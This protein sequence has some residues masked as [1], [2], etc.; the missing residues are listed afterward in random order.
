MEEHV[1]LIFYPT[2]YLYANIRNSEAQVFAVSKMADII[3][4]KVKRCTARSKPRIK[5]PLLQTR[6]AIVL[7]KAAFQSEKE[8]AAVTDNLQ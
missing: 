6:A 7:H 1:P 8:R 3:R 4:K 2:F 5:S